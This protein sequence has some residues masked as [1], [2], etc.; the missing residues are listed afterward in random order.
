[1]PPQSRRLPNIR[2]LRRQVAIKRRRESRVPDTACVATSYGGQPPFWVDA[3]IVPVEVRS[4]SGFTPWAQNTIQN[5]GE[6]GRTATAE[7]QVDVFFIRIPYGSA[8]G[9]TGRLHRVART[10]IRK[11]NSPLLVLKEPGRRRGSGLWWLS[12]PVGHPRGD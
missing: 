12:M 4:K 8:G 5:T 9:R 11:T 2:R 6:G 10:S 1:M 3:A 7:G